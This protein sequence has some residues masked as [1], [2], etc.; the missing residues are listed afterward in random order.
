[1]KV[2]VV[3]NCVTAV[4]VDTLQLIHPDWDV[5]GVDA[6]RA[7]DWLLS[8][9]KPEFVSFVQ[10]CQ[11][12]I[13]DDPGNRPLAAYLNPAADR[14]IIPQI[15]FRGLHPDITYLGDFRGPLS[16]RN[17]ANN[18][19]SLIV[20]GAKL[21]GL[22]PET[23]LELFNET[24]FEAFGYFDVYDGERAKLLETFGAAGI[25]LTEDVKLW[26]ASGDFFFVPHHPRK[27]V[28]AGVLR[29]A[30]LGRYI[31]AGLHAATA[32]VHEKQPERLGI[33][34]IWPVYP[35]LARRQGFAGSTI[36]QKPLQPP[37][38]YTL[39]EFIAASFE[40]MDTTTAK[41]RDKPQIPKAAAL[42][43]ELLP[44]LASRPRARPAEPEA[45]PAAPEA[46]HAEPAAAAPEPPPPDP[47]LPG[48]WLNAFLAWDAV[49]SQLPDQPATYAAFIAALRGNGQAAQAELV[50]GEAARRFTT[51]P[52]FALDHARL[53]EQR[54][55]W[56]AALARWDLVRTLFPLLP[57]AHIRA[58]WLLR[59]ELGR[60]EEAAQVLEEAA[61]RF[62]YRPEV[63]QEYA[64]AAV[65]RKD[66][67]AAIQ[68]YRVMCD[69]FPGMVEAWR[70]LVLQLREE[71]R[72]D[73]ADAAAMDALIRFP[74]DAQLLLERA[75]VAHHRL[76]W[77]EAAVRWQSAITSHPDLRMANWMLA[78]VLANGLNRLDEADDLLGECVERFPDHAGMACDYA[79]LAERQGDLAGA[80]ERWSAAA[81]RFPN[82]AAIAAS[83]AKA[84]AAEARAKAPVW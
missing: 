18:Q 80:V 23:T 14:L 17:T 65:D 50:L 11:L 21:L 69:R 35:E 28:A 12:L 15:W 25:D 71:R 22:T 54:K 66:R 61:A 46:A 70:M 36:F 72:F 32:N 34:E 24:T 33:M 9:E 29:R 56:P 43:E 4:Y 38:K 10:D 3:T 67:A 79:R 63:W 76:D 27:M 59:K 83:A 44:G 45:E 82:D 31:D 5:R 75:W 55:D 57:Q 49:R 78:S 52:D 51:T 64:A 81:R 39:P 40:A 6:K 73:E 62:P 68:L 74:N 60:P 53:A 42:I 77:P 1:M 2:I 8:G 20:C 41:W 58:G 26:E 48:R 16:G 47:E 19:S 30:L 7:E 13:G 84:V 37:L